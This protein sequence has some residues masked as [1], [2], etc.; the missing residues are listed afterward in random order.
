MSPLWI[1]VCFA[2]AAG[3][4]LQVIIEVMA[5]LMRRGGVARLFEGPVAGGL[6]SGLAVMY[7][8]ALLT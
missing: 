8:T 1:T 7:A 3:A 5:L 4:I 6:A 2:I